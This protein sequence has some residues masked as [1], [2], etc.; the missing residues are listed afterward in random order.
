MKV[1]IVGLGF[2]LGYLAHVFSVVRPDFE[3]VGYVDPDSAGLAYM[4]QRGVSPGTRYDSLEA[5]LETAGLDLLMVGSPNVFH[6]EHIRI[7]LEHGMKIFSEKPVV[8]D[9]EQTLA[10]A[11][12]L[13][14]FPS[15]QLMV[16]FVM[17]YAP[18]YQA[19]K[20]A[21]ADNM[22]GPIASI[23]AAEHIAPFHGAF[24]MRDWRRYTQYSGGFM[25]EKCCH[26][27]DLYNSVVGARPARVASFGGRR[28]FIP[29]NRPENWGANDTEV[30]FRKPSGW[31]GTDEVFESDADIVDSQTAL[32]EY[33]NG[34][35]L[36]F[37]ANS[38][39]ADQFR[40]FC[41][42]GARG[43]A[44]GDFIRGFMKVHDARTSECLVDSRFP[45]STAL[46]LHYGADEQMAADVYD[47]V[48]D[49][50]PLPVSAID[51]LE[52]G[53]LV[54]MIEQARR[55]R[56]VIELADHWIA[57]DNALGR[58]TVRDGVV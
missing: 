24:F 38:N 15:D 3:V 52:V 12:L 43:M 31:L 46:S 25:L 4:A 55:T 51:A 26:D 17:R 50:R 42:V 7:G 34:A 8:V 33:E 45:R 16:G 47:H 20:Q 23:E 35:S 32:I 18:L 53:L 30:Y 54:Y 13:S 6:L 40:R 10:L 44:E 36:A 57:F 1:G 22:L 11:R 29:E 19:L 27:L 37:H 2:R 28:S 9:L 48:L 14:D 49:G 5:M 41:I 58:A 56:S 39:V 21:Q